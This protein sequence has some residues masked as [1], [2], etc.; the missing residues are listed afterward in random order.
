MLT[1]ERDLE[2]FPQAGAV[3]RR[4]FATRRPEERITLAK[5]VAP[6]VKCKSA[7][8]E[9]ENQLDRTLESLYALNLTT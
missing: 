1:S 4:Y 5:P 8:A 9:H 7:A 6:G 2:S 3:R